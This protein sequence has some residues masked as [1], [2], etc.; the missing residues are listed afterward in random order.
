MAMSWSPQPEGLAELVG[1]FRQSTSTER[2]V[3]R[4]IAQR[5]DSISTIPDYVNY[6]IYVFLQMTDESVSTRSV[7]GL[8][9][10]NHI[11]FNH[12][13]IAPEIIQ[14]V[15][16]AILPALALPDTV[17]RSVASQIIAVL[18][19]V[20]KP[21]NWVEGLSALTAAMDSSNGDEVECALST[22]AK[23][24]EDMPEDLESTEIQGV[25]P[26]DVLVPKLLAATQSNDSR[27]RVHALNALSQFIQIG[28]VSMAA[29]IDDFVAALFSRANDE[30]AVVRKFVCKALVHVLGTWPEKLAPEMNNVVEYMLYSIQDGDEDVAL[31]AA[32]FWLQFA[33]EP[34]LADQLRPHI[35]RLVPVLLRSM[36]YSE[37]SLLMLADVHDDAA[38]PDRPEDIRPRHYG[39]T[40]HR[41]EHVEDESSQG[42]AR[43]RA[44]ADGEA[45]DDDYDYDEDEDDDD[46]DDEDDVLGSW[47]LRKCAAAALD[48][49]AVRFQNDILP[50]LLPLLKERLFSSDWVQREAGI[51]ALGA[52][53][54]GAMSGIVPHLPTLV[55]LLVGTLRDAQP[56]VRSI[57]C[58]TIGRYAP[59][60]VGD[61][62]PEHQQQFLMPVIEGLLAMV[63]D[64][65]KRVQEAGCSAFATLEEE[66]GPV[67][68]PFLGPVLRT[69]VMAFDKYHQR[70]MLI[71]YDAVGTLADSVGGALNDPEYIEVLMVPLIRR[72]QSLDD[73][74]PD[75]IPLL[76]CLASVTIAMGSGFLPHAPPVFQRCVSIVHDN[77]A[78]YQMAGGDDD[79]LPD[80]TFLIVAFDLL[81]GL[82][83]GIG[84]NMR[85]LV[86]ASQPPLIPLLE[87]CLAN[88]EPAVRQSAYALLG[89][90]SLSAFSELHARVPA[91][92]PVLLAEVV[93]E[94]PPEALSACNNATWAAGEIALQCGAEQAY[95][96]W[97]P[98]LLN[99]L[100]SI[101]H[102]PKSVKSLSE[103]A[104]VTIGRIGLVA[105]DSVAPH[106]A[107]F[108]E[109]W[110][111]ALWDIKDNEEKDSAFRGLCEMIRTNPNG[112]TSG[113][114]YFCNAVVRWNKPSAQLNEMFRSILVAFR[115]M[116]GSQWEAT[117][118]QFPPVI[119][120]RL[121]ER[122]GV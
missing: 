113:F 114:A 59:W 88:P 60:I 112:A 81:S 32:E 48:V 87:A 38:E 72:W 97:V 75:L 77:L 12:A 93:S 51:L 5:L 43:G 24:S 58:W 106:L 3:Q 79:D 111:Q 64:N 8:L 6:L 46:Y 16:T 120:E 53:A 76:E 100:I 102:N 70:N 31:E 122:Y 54:E 40:T 34:R 20:V 27:V 47:N 71:L 117:K 4:Q 25:R 109:P 33:E 105:P 61:T 13:R 9:A 68:V 23:L 104:A 73:L 118:A 57:T 92:M 115:D 45:D 90:L 41:S 22:L 99:K 107:V 101:L 110:C 14:H 42:A 86:A 26:L 52:V 30:R 62:T 74:D 37:L 55:P 69:L 7:A 96:Q 80:R 67:L 91:I 63:L 15:E 121:E 28:S 19:Q 98:E 21:Q 78:A 66:A 49:L 84:A 85:E 56:L 35:E 108:I 83:Q 2:D 39:G 44:A 11:Y 18:M 103:N 17:L 50:V 119:R 10:K 89:D 29:N 94:P 82:S 36:V 95:Q 116:S 65:N 1:L